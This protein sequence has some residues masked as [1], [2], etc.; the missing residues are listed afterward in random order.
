MTIAYL[1]NTTL[2]RG[3]AWLYGLLLFTGV[4]KLPIS[5]HY[6]ASEERECVPQNN[7]VPRL[8]AHDY[9]YIMY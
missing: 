5:V 1:R 7:S 9:L 2:L 4:H 6:N 3:Q 8:K